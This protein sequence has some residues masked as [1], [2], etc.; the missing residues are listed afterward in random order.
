MAKQSGMLS[1][2]L[3]SALE[4]ACSELALGRPNVVVV[5]PAVRSQSVLS[6]CTTYSEKDCDRGR[7]DELDLYV[8][9]KN[10]YVW[11]L[12]E[13]PNEDK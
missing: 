9:N 6:D 3:R 12:P 1:P 7:P 8:L 13:L 4:Q 11:P 2:V 10:H 5:G